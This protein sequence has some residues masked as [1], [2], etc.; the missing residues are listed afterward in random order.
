M[1]T[2]KRNR[3]AA[4]LLRRWGIGV[5]VVVAWGVFSTVPASAEDAEHISSYDVAL[6]VG[7]GGSMGVTETIAYDFGT[8]RRHGIFRTIPTKVPFDN[9]NFRLYPLSDV[10]VTSPDGAPTDVSRSE[11]AGVTTL[12]IGD[13]DKTITG[14][15]TYV[16]RYTVDGA[17]NSFPD[18]VELY[19]NAIGAE[20]SVPIERA[21]VHVI[22]PAPI[23]QQVCFAG[24]TGGTEPCSS[25]TLSDKNEAEFT[26]GAG[27]RRTARSRSR[28]RCQ[29]TP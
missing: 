26:Q 22:A 15:H 16:L 1:I 29:A 20:W 27:C 14:R 9:D 8:N 11:A 25:G 4:D 21:T 2:T 10:R 24:V 19:W 28:S 18:R 12:R 6:T 17:L 13:P 7:A 3:R 5:L 23:Q